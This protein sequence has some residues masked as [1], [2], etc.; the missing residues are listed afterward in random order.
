MPSKNILLI[1]LSDM[2]SGSSRALFPNKMFP[3]NQGETNHTPTDIQK[4]IYDHWIQCAEWAK[5]KRKGKHVI[6][7]HNGDAIEGIHHNSIQVVSPDWDD[8]VA[9]HIDLI[10]TFRKTAGITASDQM[11]YVSGTE[12]HTKNYEETIAAHFDAEP[13][14][15]IFGKTLRLHH[16]LRLQIHGREIWFTHHGANAGK[17][18]NEGNGL[19]NWLRD[20]YWDSKRDNVTPPDLVYTAHHHKSTYTSYVQDWHT[21]HGV[22]L[23]SWQAKTRYALRA[24]PFQ[25]NDIGMAFSEIT[26]DGDIRVYPSLI[27][28]L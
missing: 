6:M 21:I 27:A 16:E 3:M 20:I 22:I 1:T 19:R 9:I 14:G 13:A 2:H 12:S 7:V 17:G 25:R 5:S 4:K 26:S 23:P 15:E 18:A 11:Y 24:A 8:H 10:E 28:K